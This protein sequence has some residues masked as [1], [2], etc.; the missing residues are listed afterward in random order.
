MTWEVAPEALGSKGRSGA[1]TIDMRPGLSGLTPEAL[2]R[3]VAEQGQPAYRARQI[4]DAVWK[5]GG[6]AAARR[7]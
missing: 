5:D 2:D 7:S 1:V 3:W 6:V 4:A